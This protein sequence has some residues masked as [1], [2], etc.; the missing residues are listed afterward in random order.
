VNFNANFN[1][2]LNRYLA[3]SAS[4]AENKKYFD[5]IRTQRGTAVKKN[6]FIEFRKMQFG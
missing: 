4:V 1:V 2:P 3:Y 5:N 6:L